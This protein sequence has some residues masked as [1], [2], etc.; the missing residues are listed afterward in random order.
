[1]DGAPLQGVG[2]LNGRQAKLK[3]KNINMRLS[4]LTSIGFCANMAIDHKS[5]VPF[6]FD[7]LYA[8]AEEGRLVSLLMESIDD[9]GAIEL[10]AEDAQARAEVE[11]SLANAIEALRG[12]EIR[13]TGVGDNPLCMVIAIVLEAIQQN[14]H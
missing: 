8:A 10:W 14:F 5:R 3:E 13:K 4:S 6:T 7:D 9:S 12:Q 2:F 11:R 1:M